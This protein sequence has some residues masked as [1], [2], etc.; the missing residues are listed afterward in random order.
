MDAIDVLR[1]MHVSVKAAFREIETAPMDKRRALWAA[2]QPELQLHEEMEELF[3]YGPM[4]EDLSDPQGA[5]CDWLQHHQDQVAEA[6]SIMSRIE[7]LD[8]SQDSWLMEVLK[9]KSALDNHI[10]QEEVMVWPE[11]RSQWGQEKLEQRTGPLRAAVT[12]ATGT[13]HGRAPDSPAEPR[14]TS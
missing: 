3:V 6:E 4:S 7:A 9:L 5:L 10:L 1:E 11:I 12:A 8:P 13:P 2:L 14:V